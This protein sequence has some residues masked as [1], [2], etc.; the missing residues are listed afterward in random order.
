MKHNYTHK[1]NCVRGCRHT[2]THK[3]TM[4]ASSSRRPFGLRLH[5]HRQ[6]PTER[7]FAKA[8]VR[9]LPSR[10]VAYRTEAASGFS[11]TRL[12]LK[13]SVPRTGCLKSCFYFKASPCH[14]RLR[15]CCIGISLCLLRIDIFDSLYWYQNWS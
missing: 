14:S 9:S 3:D 12:S 11:G 5:Y 7:W 4:W 1:T 8:V 6:L 13:H 10:Y 2:H 15:L